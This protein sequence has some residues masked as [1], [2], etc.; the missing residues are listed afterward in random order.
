MEGLLRKVATVFRDTISTMRG[1]EF[2][3]NCQLAYSFP[4]GACGDTSM[5]LGKYL[6]DE[7]KID[8]NYVCGSSLIDGQEGW[9]HA[10]LEYGRL[11]ID[12]TADQFED[13]EEEVIIMESYP[14]YDF[15]ETDKPKKISECFPNELQESYDILL[16][17]IINR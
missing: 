14:L 13:V 7:F 2:P 4:R 6:L 15:Y 8:C 1:S 10:W 17:A 9:T 16:D 3:S 11:K 5:L 12:I